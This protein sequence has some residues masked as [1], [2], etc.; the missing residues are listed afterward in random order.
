MLY[1]TDEV[2][3]SW[4]SHFLWPFFR[5]SGFLVIVPIMGSRL[6]PA[7]VRI[8]LAFLMTLIIYPLMPAMPVIEAVNLQNFIMIAEQIIIG[9]TLGFI[10]LMMMQVFVLAGQTISMQMGLGFASMV[11]PSN[12]ISVAVLSQW[13]QVLVTLV[14]LAINGHLLVL[15]VVIDSFYTLPIGEGLFG[16]DQWRVLAE[17]GSWLYKASLTLALPAITALLL[18]NLAFGVMTRAAPQLNVFAL[19]FPV[20]MMT[21]LVIVWVSYAAAAPLVEQFLETHVSLMR[22]LIRF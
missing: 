17:F 3:A 15:E 8:S 19:G 10:V 5:L 2:I 18:V 6:V 1:V 4:V 20:T 22:A 21:G 14:F 9:T 12:G 13:Y 16:A 7:R 11:D